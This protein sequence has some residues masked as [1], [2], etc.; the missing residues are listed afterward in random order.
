[1]LRAPKAASTA[2]FTRHI[3]RKFSKNKFARY[4]T[5]PLIES[6]LEIQSKEGRHYGVPKA[7]RLRGFGLALPY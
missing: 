7:E 5:D 1:F 4:L 2:V 6:F 3:V